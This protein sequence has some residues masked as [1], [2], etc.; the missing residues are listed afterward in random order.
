MTFKTETNK[1]DNWDFCISPFLA[2]SLS[3]KISSAFL[4]IEKFLDLMSFIYTWEEGGTD[5]LRKERVEEKHKE[6]I[7]AISREVELDN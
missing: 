1:I 6:P 4:K 5:Y 2:F 3:I 7:P